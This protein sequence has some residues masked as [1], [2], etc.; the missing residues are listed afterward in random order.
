[1]GVETPEL[2]LNGIVQ[3]ISKRCCSKITSEQAAHALILF[4]CRSQA[5][6]RMLSQELLLPRT[7]EELYSNHTL[8]G[9]P[10]VQ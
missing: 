6:K 9:G 3:F 1:M 8:I 4:L 10:K 5:S 7:M 2:T